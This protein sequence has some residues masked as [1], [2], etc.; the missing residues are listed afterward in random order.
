MGSNPTWGTN[1]GTTMKYIAVGCLLASL[2][3]TMGCATKPKDGPVENEWESVEPP[4]GADP[5]AC[6]RYIIISIGSGE[7]SSGIRCPKREEL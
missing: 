3:L 2:L 5:Y 4:R 1:K 6:R 7:M